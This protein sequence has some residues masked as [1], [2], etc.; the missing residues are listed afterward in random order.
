MS[1][2]VRNAYK[3]HKGHKIYLYLIRD[4]RGGQFTYGA[5]FALVRSTYT[6]KRI[7]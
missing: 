7:E 5:H 3:G 6:T 2:I 1:R 4:L